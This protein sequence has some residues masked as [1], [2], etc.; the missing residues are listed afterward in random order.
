M[1]CYLQ[2]DQLPVVMHADLEP[3]TLEVTVMKWMAEQRVL[4]AVGEVDGQPWTLVMNFGA[5][6]SAIV[7]AVPPSDAKPVLSWSDIAIEKL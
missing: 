7:S 3:L 6:A 2:S 4:R 1:G 5:I